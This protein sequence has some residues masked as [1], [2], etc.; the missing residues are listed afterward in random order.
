MEQL[1]ELR[2]QGLIEHLT[3]ALEHAK[4]ISLD[5]PDAIYGV[6]S[7]LKF[8][9]TQLSWIVDLEET[10]TIADVVLPMIVD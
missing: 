10:D 1:L 4:A 9:Q 6:Q 2:K 3:A 5:A 7:S 8:A